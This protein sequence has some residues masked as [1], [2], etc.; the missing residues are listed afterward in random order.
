MEQSATSNKSESTNPALVNYKDEE[1][2]MSESLYRNLHVLCRFYEPSAEFLLIF[3]PHMFIKSNPKAFIVVIHFIFN[4]LDTTEFN[5]RFRWPVFDK[6]AETVFRKA[7]LDYMNHLNVT[8]QLGLE[9]LKLSNIHIPGGL[10]FIKIIH[11]FTYLAMKLELNKPEHGPLPN[12]QNIPDGDDMLAKLEQYVDRGMDY[13]MRLQGQSEKLSKKI[14][15]MHA[16]MEAFLHPTTESN[17]QKSCCACMQQKWKENLDCVARDAVAPQL[18]AMNLLSKNTVQL[19]QLLTKLFV[20]K[21]E[22]IVEYD[23]QQLM[24]AQNCLKRRYPDSVQEIDGIVEGGIINFANLFKVFSM[25]LPTMT[26]KFKTVKDKDIEAI[27]YELNGVV[28]YDE[29][30]TKYLDTF[31]DYKDMLQPF[32][33]KEMENYLQFCHDNFNLQFE[34][35][36]TPFVARQL[37]VNGM[38]NRLGL[39]D[40]AKKKTQLFKKPSMRGTAKRT[41]MLQTSSCSTLGGY[42][43]HSAA[44]QLLA[45]PKSRSN[46]SMSLLSLPNM[47]NFGRFSTPKFS[48]TMSSSAATNR[49]QPEMKI[50]P[51]FPM[52][53]TGVLKNVTE[54]TSIMSPNGISVVRKVSTSSVMHLNQPHIRSPTRR[55]YV[56]NISPEFAAMMESDAD[57]DKIINE[58]RMDRVDTEWTNGR[59]LEMVSEGL[60][61]TNDGSTFHVASLQTDQDGVELISNVSDSVLNDILSE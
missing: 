41:A 9:T 48:S 7:A 55:F 38:R 56:T 19:D 49:L 1:K 18:E 32:K 17:K 58:H 12:V 6:A 11:K 52:T 13:A 21:K 44:M 59:R 10:K 16:M 53:P 39:I 31:N 24:V 46:T 5:K 37:D 60:E 33:E 42:K 45:K 47:S 54:T 27:E 2:L 25:L 43:T 36:K 50:S 57:L 4:C 3:Q 30:A 15:E 8:H 29:I 14:D 23:R 35:L 26:N 28:E 40:D 22:N 61:D 34:P 20:E 51:V